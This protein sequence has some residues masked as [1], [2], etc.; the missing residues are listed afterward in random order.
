MALLLISF[1]S[2]AL[3]GCVIW[4]VVED[5]PIRRYH[6][7]VPKQLMVYV[8]SSAALVYLTLFALGVNRWI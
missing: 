3:I 7:S 1:I 5:R 4:L 2:G 8:L 6:L